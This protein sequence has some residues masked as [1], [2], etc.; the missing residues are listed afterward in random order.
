MYLNEN[1][2][3]EIKFGNGVLGKKLSP[4]DKVHVLYLDTNGPDGY[5]DFSDIDITADG[6]KFEHSASFLGMSDWLYE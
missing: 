5:I 4:G 3:Y 1:K 2:T 6:R